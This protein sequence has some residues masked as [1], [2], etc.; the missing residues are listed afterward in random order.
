MEA[1]GQTPSSPASID[2]S[3][4]KGEHSDDADLESALPGDSLLRAPGTTTTNGMLPTPVKTPKKKAV[5]DFSTTSRSLF[6]SSS[7]S[8]RSTKG[9]KSSGFSLESFG[10]EP[11]S[12]QS[13]EIYTDFR[14]RIPKVHEGNPF[15]KKSGA[16]RSRNG[17]KAEGTS[18]DKEVNE[19]LKR[20]D[21][22]F[23]VL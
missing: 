3:P 6:P 16:A 22:M 14:D 7:A 17:C 19:A 1:E 2:H 5:G 20:D 10:D 23:Y 11:S 9:G 18:R 4:K 12:R 8:S 21:G 13:I 15:Y